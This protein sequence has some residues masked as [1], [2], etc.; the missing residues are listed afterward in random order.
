[1]AVSMIDNQSQDVLPRSPRD[2]TANGS[3]REGEKGSRAMGDGMGCRVFPGVWMND[4][5]DDT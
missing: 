2:I 4:T 1:M 3:E 5:G